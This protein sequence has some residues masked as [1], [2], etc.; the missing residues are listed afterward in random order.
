MTADRPAVHMSTLQRFLAPI[1]AALGHAARI[2]FGLL[3]IYLLIRTGALEPE[4]L[5]RA[6]ARHPL[7]YVASFALYVSLLQFMACGRWYWLL[8]SAGVPIRLRTT[9]RLHMMGLFFSGFLPG[10]TGGDLVKG[11]YL[12]KGRTKA[13]GAAA[14]GTLVVDRIVGLF[15]LIGVAAIATLASIPVWRDAPLLAA[16]STFILAI[17]LGA[18]VVTLGYLSPWNPLAFLFKTGA[19]KQKGF[20]AELA[21][22]LTAFRKTPGVFLGAI[23][24]SMGVHFCLIVIYALCARALDVDLPFRLHAYVGPVLTFVN[25]IPISPAGLGVGEA[26]GRVLYKAVGAT[27]GQAEIPALVHTLGLL[28]ALICAPA[29]FFRRRRARRP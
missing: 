28:T 8:R 1:R 19:G 24:I 5:G 16:Q 4:L 22:A 11:Y 12:M 10:G 7:L 26:A 27:H 23:A 20:L 2:G 25:G 29:Y 21:G 14:L 13:E 17:A 9:V 6:I 15:G 18:L 3:A